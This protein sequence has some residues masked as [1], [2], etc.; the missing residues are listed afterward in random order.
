[1]G[2]KK[3]N[4]KK[5]KFNLNFKKL[6][7]AFEKNV[8][9]KK[10]FNC[11]KKFFQFKLVPDPYNQKMGIKMK[12]LLTYLELVHNEWLSKDEIDPDID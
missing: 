1:M 2:K 10:E 8:L 7:M 4:K 6:L 9:K 12:I 11:C 5:V 3:L